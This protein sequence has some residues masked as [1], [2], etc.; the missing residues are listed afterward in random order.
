MAGS[1]SSIE[2]KKRTLIASLDESR[3]D[4]VIDFEEVGDFLNIPSQ[5][6]DSFHDG[7]WKW[8][9]V[10]LVAGVATGFV[11]LPNKRLKRSLKEQI[12]GVAKVKD[13]G[14]GPLVGMLL[15]GLAKGGFA[16]ARPTLTKMATEAVE[17]WA[18][19]ASAKQ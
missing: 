2:E 1:E 13:S 10:V 14:K 15:A 9:G 7:K 8:L 16:L 17:K 19:G 5:I 11:V 4:L 6:R 18:K 3:N 12:K